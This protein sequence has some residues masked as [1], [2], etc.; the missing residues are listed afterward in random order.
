MVIGYAGMRYLEVSIVSPVQNASGALSAIVM[1]IWFT[2]TG[3]IG[4]FWEEFSIV[5]VIGTVLIVCGVIA[6]GIVEQKLAREEKALDLPE[7]D[8]ILYGFTFF[9]AAVIAWIILLIKEKKPYNPFTL[10]EI[11]TR[12]A[13]AL[14]EQ[15]GQ[16]FYVYALA[17]NPIVATP[18]IASYC[19]VSAILSRIFLKEKLK[20]P[21]YA[22]IIVVIIGIVLMGI[23][24]G[25]A[26]A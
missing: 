20:A 17:K 1:F 21:Q 13:A 18:M 26:E 10:A 23:A 7:K 22:C 5:H 2:A 14:F 24:D 16:V 19:I 3:T 6:L 4:S 8:R 25:L 11:K 15:F 9:F 12:G